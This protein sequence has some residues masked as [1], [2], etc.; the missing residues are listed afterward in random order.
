[1]TARL[2]LAMF[3]TLTILFGACTSAGANEGLDPAPVR[4]ASYSPL[5]GSLADGRDATQLWWTYELNAGRP[6]TVAQPSVQLTLMPTSARVVV[7][8]LKKTRKTQVSGSLKAVAGGTNVSGGF[9]LSVDDELAPGEPTAFVNERVHM[10]QQLM[11]QGE[12]VRVD[13]D[14]LGVPDGPWPWVLDRSDLGSTPEGTRVDSVL[15]WKITGTIEEQANGA[16][17]RKTL[18]EQTISSADSWIVRAKL[19]ALSVQGVDYH[20]VVQVD[21]Q[22]QA[23]DPTTGVPT[24]TSVT[25]YVAAGV[26]FVRA[27]NLVK[28]PGNQDV[29]WDLIDTNLQPV[30]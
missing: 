18:P 13:I 12:N 27:V 29:I 8:P 11:A 21:R 20:D 14:V 16:T 24:P 25:Y 30:P 19:P 10:T 2:R 3:A 1:M 4:S 6:I 26:G 22:M 15:G 28:L 17:D 9:E 7:E 23:P 5:D